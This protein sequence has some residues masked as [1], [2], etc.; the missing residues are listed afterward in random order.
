[1]L[2][3]RSE[4]DY[5]PT[6]FLAS[7]IASRGAAAQKPRAANDEKKISSSDLGLENRSRALMK[8]AAA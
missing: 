2:P 3:I 7:L 6:S 1:M 8:D 5:S 4:Y